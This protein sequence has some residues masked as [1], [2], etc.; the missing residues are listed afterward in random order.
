MKYI[1]FLSFLASA[2]NSLAQAPGISWKKTYGGTDFETG[3]SIQNTSDGGYVFVGQSY[4]FNGDLTSN[5]GKGDLWVCKINSTGVITWQKT[6]GGTALESGSSIKQTSDGGYIISGGSWSSN[7]DVNK[8]QGVG[9]Y[10]VLKLD[11]A[12]AI[13]WQKTYGGSGNEYA[14]SIDTT[15][16]GGYIVAGWTTSNDGDVIGSHGN[17]DYW[18]L[19][20]NDTG[21]ILWSKTYGGTNS[22]NASAIQHTYDGGF[23][24][25]GTTLSDNGDVSFN[26]QPGTYDMWILKLTATGTIS[27]QKSLGGTNN[28]GAFSV[29]QTT[30][31]GY[32]IAGETSSIDGDVTINHGG[33]DSWVIKLDR[34][35][36]LTWQKSFGGTNSET[37]KDIIQTN[38]GGYALLS[39]AES[40]DGDVSFNNGSVDYWIVKLNSAGTLIWQKPFG[41]SGDD[42]P[43]SIIQSSDNGYVL[44]GETTSTNGDVTGNHGS[45]DCWAIKLNGIPSE[46]KT[47]E[48]NNK[49][50]SVYPTI[51]SGYIYIKMNGNHEN[52]EFRVL[53]AFGQTTKF[54]IDDSKEKTVLDISGNARGTYILQVINNG[55]VESYKIILQ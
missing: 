32:I 33:Y 49:T 48:Y 31:S 46:I 9:D 43:Y 54:N 53:N 15:L 40:S 6:Y 28:D 10:W 2:F 17:D 52:S 22:D 44:F 24:V 37:T 55:T 45:N 47:T 38:D 18:I 1:F 51:T 14:M 12:G 3:A 16:D 35:G 30:D 20:L 8:N 23:V 4:S 26:H 19:K 39:A 5:H 36:K 25:A 13:V 41:G 42:I 34:S 29:R 27:W 50:S 11:K 21:K 7:G